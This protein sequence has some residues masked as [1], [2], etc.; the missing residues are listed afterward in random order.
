MALSNLSQGDRMGGYGRDILV[1]GSGWNERTSD[2]IRCG[3]LI[4]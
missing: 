1:F 2:S 4:D 3:I